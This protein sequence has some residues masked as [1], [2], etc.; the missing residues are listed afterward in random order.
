MEHDEMMI[1]DSTAINDV[2]LNDVFNPDSGWSFFSIG[3]C[4]IFYGEFPDPKKPGTFQTQ[5]L[6]MPHPSGTVG[7]DSPDAPLKERLAHF[8]STQCPAYIDFRNSTHDQVTRWAEIRNN[9]I[10]LARCFVDLQ[11]SQDVLNCF[12]ENQ[13]T[14]A[15]SWPYRQLIARAGCFQIIYEVFTQKWDEIKIAFEQSAQCDASYS[16]PGD[17][18][19]FYTA[20]LSEVSGHEI[21]RIF[22]TYFKDLSNYFGRLVSLKRRELGRASKGR[23]G[24]TRAEMKE[25]SEK[26]QHYLGDRNT[27]FPKLQDVWMKLALYDDAWLAEKFSAYCD[28]QEEIYRLEQA[29]THKPELKHHRPSETWEGGQQRQRKRGKYS[30]APQK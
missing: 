16:S 14:S 11:S 19:D 30:K 24:L 7:S 27:F 3:Y 9:F 17:P 6:M 23:I 20:L 22:Q 2:D 8:M 29:A 28:L 13:D 26:W 10:D 21:E 15:E 1:D 5:F 18:Y 25:L 4:G 12:A